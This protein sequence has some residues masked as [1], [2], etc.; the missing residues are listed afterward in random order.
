MLFISLY[1][2]NIVHLETLPHKFSFFSIFI[3]LATNHTYA[4]LQGSRSDLMNTGVYEAQNAV[5]S[6]NIGL[7]QSQNPG[8]YQEEEDLR[9]TRKKSEKK[10]EKFEVLESP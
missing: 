9:L 4:E 8:V 2:I 6:Q 5:Q 3:V 10:R 7:Y 1:I